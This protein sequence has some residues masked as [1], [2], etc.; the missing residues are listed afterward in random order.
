MLYARSHRIL[1][2]SLLGRSTVLNPEEKT[3][4]KKRFLTIYGFAK[5]S[6]FVFRNL[7]V[8]QK[9]LIQNTPNSGYLPVFLKNQEF[10]GF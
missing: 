7:R 4:A 5:S 2:T 9:I 1:S 8:R 10:F 3:L 6:I